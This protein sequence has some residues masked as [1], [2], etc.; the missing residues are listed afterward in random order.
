MIKGEQ[1]RG[2]VAVND[3][4]VSV[5]DNTLCNQCVILVYNRCVTGGG[6]NSEKPP[7]PHPRVQG[8]S[9]GVSVP[10]QDTRVRASAPGEVPR[11][12]R[13]VEPYST[14]STGAEESQGP[15]PLR[16]VAPKVLCLHCYPSG[17][18]DA[19]DDPGRPRSAWP[20]ARTRIGLS[21]RCRQGC[22]APRKLRGAQGRP[23]APPYQ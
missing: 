5:A 20:T 7:S 15:K 18:R 14:G 3:I 4:I 19:W 16:G 12:P 13:Q 6:T 11:R 17:V 23:R 8:V 10:C 22:R 9:N 2:H 21:H 1:G